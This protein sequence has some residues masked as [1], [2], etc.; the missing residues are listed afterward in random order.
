VQ[1]HEHQHI[2]LLDHVI[3]IDSVIGPVM[4]ER[5]IFDRDRIDINVRQV[6]ESFV[7]LIEFCFGV[8]RNEHLFRHVTPLSQFI[9]RT[10]QCSKVHVLQY[11]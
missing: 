1:Q 6:E 4:I 2:R 11:L 10:A 8:I 3:A 9:L 5:E 7:L